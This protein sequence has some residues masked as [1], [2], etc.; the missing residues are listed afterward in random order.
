MNQDKILM[1]ENIK[2]LLNKVDTPFY[3]YS[4]E[5]LEKN[6]IDI[7]ERLTSQIELCY[8]IKAN[9]ILVPYVQTFVNYF[10]VCSLGE[11]RIC[12]QIVSPDKNIIFGGVC[13]KKE[14]IREAV[15]DNQVILT[16]ESMSQLNNINQISAE[17]QRV[18]KV[19][20]RLSIGNQFGIAADELLEMLK[21]RNNF[22]NINITG[23]QQYAATQCF[24]LEEERKYIEK[25]FKI[26]EELEEAVDYQ[27][28]MVS[29]G[30][31]IGIPYY[32]GDMGKE[33]PKE[34]LSGV[35]DL[36]ISHKKGRKI[37]Y[38]AGRVIPASSGIY[39]SR[40]LDQKQT[41]G[42]TYSILDGGTNHVKYYGH[43]FGARKIITEL[44]RDEREKDV[45]TICG[46]LCTVNDILLKDVE[47]AKHSIDD[48]LLFLNAGAYCQTEASALFL[49][50]DLPAVYVVD[51]S[52]EV[53]LIRD[54][55]NTYSINGGLPTSL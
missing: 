9:S 45:Y 13:K 44:L 21:E 20:L 25:L 53:S 4:L 1:K 18:S 51:E 5:W 52:N 30:G 54:V 43:T 36:L 47:I 15:K 3:I 33:N 12:K 7:K 23:I 46:A 49:S 22:Q 39:V 40:V 41:N 27:F 8:S 50:R 28:E 2:K 34:I 14:E 6:I 17:E 19:I 42:R 11:Y 48:V 10:E 26:I 32:E 35:A 24:K 16:V 29:Y 55:I 38:E 37:I 31:G